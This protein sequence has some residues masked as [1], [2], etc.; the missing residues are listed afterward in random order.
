MLIAQA[1]DAG[2]TVATRDEVFD[3]Y[4]VPVLVA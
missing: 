3:R 4:G 2:F 1:L